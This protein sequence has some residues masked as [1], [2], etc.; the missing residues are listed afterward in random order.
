MNILH[1]IC[2]AQ[3]PVLPTPDDQYDFFTRIWE[4]EPDRAV[5]TAQEGM[6]STSG[7][8]PP[9]GEESAEGVEEAKVAEVDQITT[10]SEI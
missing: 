10:Y 7:E 5:E 6:P 2:C 1:Y 3:G 9:T 8:T 4:P